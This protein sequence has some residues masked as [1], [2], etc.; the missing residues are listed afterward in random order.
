MINPDFLYLKKRM[1][2]CTYNLLLGI[3]VC[4]V[5]SDIAGDVTATQG[6]SLKEF[7]LLLE[8]RVSS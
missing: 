5:S 7:P 4:C 6:F 8:H 3:D 1:P 2:A